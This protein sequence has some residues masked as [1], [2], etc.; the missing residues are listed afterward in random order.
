MSAFLKIDIFRKLPRDLTE[1]TFCGAIV[2]VICAITLVLLTIS[3]LATYLQ[4]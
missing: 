1:P 2:S 3:E 4:P